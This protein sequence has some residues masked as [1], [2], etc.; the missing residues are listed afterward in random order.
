M[1]GV[2]QYTKEIEA[3]WDYVANKYQ[4]DEILGDARSQLVLRL[5]TRASHPEM[6]FALSL[7]ARLLG[8]TNAATIRVFPG[9]DATPLSPAFLNVNYPQTRSCFQ[10]GFSN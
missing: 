7:L 8:C 9:D 6:P 1:D 3:A 10:Y 4:A 2:R 5:S